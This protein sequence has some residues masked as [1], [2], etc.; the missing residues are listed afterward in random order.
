MMRNIIR[1]DS[2]RCIGCGKC[3]EACVEGAIK[4]VGGKAVLV[5][6]TF[7]DG[8]GACL[9]SCPAKA[10]SIERRNVAPLEGPSQ[11]EHLPVNDIPLTMCPGSSPRRIVS[12]G[13]TSGQLSHWPIQL[14]LVPPTAPYLEGC[15]LLVA[16]DCSAFARGDFHDRFI[17][18]RIVII[19][20]PKLDPQESWRRLHDIFSMH[21]IRSVTVTRMDV[22]CCSGIVNAVRTAIG[23]SGRDI[24]VRV[25]TIH[26]D[27]RIEED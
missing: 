19:G 12:E 7:C 15:D 27:G 8:L 1:I 9:P 2:E 14:R 4:M 22:P 26:A 3:A 21:D 24:P 20:C 6:E 13:Q 17:K 10:L 16:S 5:S 23:Q 25:C 11:T 18:G